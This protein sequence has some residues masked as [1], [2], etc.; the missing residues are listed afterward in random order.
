MK[1]EQN[2]QLKSNK[3]EMVEIKPNKSEIQEK[4]I[5]LENVQVN[6]QNTFQFELQ[7]EW[8][9]ESGVKPQ[10]SNVLVDD[11]KPK[12]LMD[13]SSN[14]LTPKAATSEEIMK[15]KPNKL[16]SEILSQSDIQSTQVIERPKVIETH[17][18]PLLLKDEKA[19]AADYGF[20]LDSKKVDE[21]IGI[22]D[23]E[24]ICKCLAYAI[25]KHIDFS[26]GEVLIDD[27]VSEDEDIPQFSYDFDN[28][29]RIDLEELQR[30]KEMEEWEAQVRNIGMII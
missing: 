12:A 23:I 29:L 6:N 3:I 18:T 13:N 26:K 20:S 14:E 19:E 1:N 8:M 15:T 21:T 7:E 27:L 10:Q 9:S 4:I 5:A 16:N 25:L 24:N 28:N 30:K 11:L 17:S 2:N 22:I